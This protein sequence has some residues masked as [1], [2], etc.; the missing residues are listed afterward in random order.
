LKKIIIK[1]DTEVI[2]FVLIFFAGVLF[3]KNIAGNISFKSTEIWSTVLLTFV[4]VLTGSYYAFKLQAKKEDEKE[5]RKK[6]EI[7]NSILIDLLAISDVFKNY[8]NIHISP[9][10]NS[11][12]S[13][14]LITNVAGFEKMV[15]PLKYSKLH[16]FTEF[17]DHSVLLRISALNVQIISTIDTIEKRQLL[18]ITV[19]QNA[20]EKVAKNNNGSINHIRLKAELGD[21]NYSHIFLSTN[22]IIQSVDQIIKETEDLSNLIK[23]Y[24]VLEYPESNFI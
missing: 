5:T 6:V 7:S 11:D 3:E 14:A 19:V 12:I 23:K 16:F 18:H 9:Y 1:S 8:R 20:V 21:K 4:S 13:Y 22:A 17:S 15:P 24:A 10:L 2:I